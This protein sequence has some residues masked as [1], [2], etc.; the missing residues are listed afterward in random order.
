MSFKDRSQITDTTGAVLYECIGKWG[1]FNPPWILLKEGREVAVF[2]RK[3]W[4]LAPTWDVRSDA[5]DFRLR[6]E[7]FSFRQRVMVQGGPFDGAELAG[8]LSGM[9]FELTRAGDLLRRR[10]RSGSPCA[11]GTTSS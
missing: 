10:A 5:G 3:A 9:R 2:R 6:S 1:W 8:S 11:S 7:L 4:S